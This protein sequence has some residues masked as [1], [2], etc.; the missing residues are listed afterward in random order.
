MTALNY[1]RLKAMAVE[2]ER[3]LSTLIVQDAN[4]DPF[5]ADLPSRRLRAEWFAEVWRR[6]GFGLGTHLRRIHYR[7]DAQPVELPRPIRWTDEAGE[8]ETTI[9]VNNRSCSIFLSDAASDARY[10]G[11]IPVEHI[12]DNRNAETVVNYQPSEHPAQVNIY[13]DED[14]GR[15]GLM[16]DAD[17][18]DFPGLPRLQVT[19]PAIAQPY[20]VELWIEKSSLDDVFEPLASK[21]GVN[22]TSGTGDISVTRAHDLIRRALQHGK[23]VRVLIVSD[24]DPGGAGMPVSQA[25]KLEFFIRHRHPEL[26]IQ[27]QPVALTAEQVQR[28]RLPRNAIK[29]SVRQANEFTRKFGA[30]ATELDALEALHPGELAKLVEKE[31]KRFVDPHLAKKVRAAVKKAQDELDEI[32]IEI[33]DQV[34]DQVADLRADHEALADEIGDYAAEV[35]EDFQR[36]FGQ[37]IDDLQGRISRLRDLDARAPRADDFEWPEASEGKP[38]DDPLFDSTRDYILQVDRFKEHQQKPTSGSLR[39]NYDYNGNG[40]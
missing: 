12:V 6:F 39:T 9:Y 30:G 25:R 17:L 26:D 14:P 20:A 19:P 3:P 28:Y 21:W 15:L 10:L 13:S 27:V 5:Y 1:G 4:A 35:E 8:H 22:F 29:E 16:V 32:N 34:E 7:L 23:P 37:R 18:P 31:I 24:F 36:R 11:L 40:K 38:F 33:E 2:L